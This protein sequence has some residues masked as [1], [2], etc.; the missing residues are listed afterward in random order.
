M[1]AQI[2]EARIGPKQSFDLAFE[3]SQAALGGYASEYD[4]KFEGVIEPVAALKKAIE[5]AIGSD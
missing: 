2:V 1:N 3:P 4:L 5:K